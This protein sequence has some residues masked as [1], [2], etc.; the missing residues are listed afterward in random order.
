M[1]IRSIALLDRTGKFPFRYQSHHCEVC[2]RTL[3]SSFKKWLLDHRGLIRLL[4]LLFVGLNLFSA[5]R[6]FFVS[7]LLVLAK[8]TV[9][10]VLLMAVILIH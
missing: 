5:H 6:T 7:L 10:V 3:M 2:Q 1:G 9:A 8:I 4:L